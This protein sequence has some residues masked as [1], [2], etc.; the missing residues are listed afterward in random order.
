MPQDSP[1]STNQESAL[2][3]KSSTFNVPALILTSPKIAD[4]KEQLQ[5][6]I[7]QAPD[8]F[9]NSPLLINLQELTASHAEIDLRSLVK[10]LRSLHFIPI[11]VSGATLKQN[12]IAL[13]LGLAVQSVHSLTSVNNQITQTDLPVSQETEA[14]LESE[15]ESEPESAAEIVTA[16][17]IVENKL[18]TQPVRS[19]QRIYAKGDLTVLAPV[20]SGAELIA[21]GNI[22]V[23]APMRGRALAGVKGNTACCIFCSDLQADLIS[24]AGIYRLSEDLDDNLKRTLVQI[25]LD[26]QTLLIKK[27]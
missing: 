2:E 16:V 17:P 24:I 11:A 19:G 22:H 18:I 1:N 4:I 13:R 20:S 9:K 26:D 6:K 3:F 15:L 8:F 27:L 25:Y 14:E 23:Y 7:S 5:A 21:E 10:T 12:N